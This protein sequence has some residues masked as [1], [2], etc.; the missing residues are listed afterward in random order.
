[1][2]IG[3]KLFELRKQKNLSQEEVAEKLNVT[4]QTVSKWETNQSTPDF[5]KIIPICELFEISTEE[6]L[7][8]KKVE[9]KNEKQESSE[10]EKFEEKTMTKEEVRR[11]SAEVVS[12]SV[13]LY[14]LSIVFIMIAIPVQKM[15]PIVASAIFLFI[16]AIA[17]TRII[18]H[19]MSIPKFD[20]TKEEKQEDDIVK[21]INSIIGAIFTA[22]YFIVS[23]MTFAWHVTWII[24]VICGAVCNIVKLIFMLKEEKSNEE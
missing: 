24:F 15:N 3:E 2:D 4:R 12:T 18:K 7:T 22:I 14:I 16:I 17:T 23:F 9:E 11:K 10:K 20:K 5:D 1:M 21:Q 8:G 6:L 19:Y 13:L